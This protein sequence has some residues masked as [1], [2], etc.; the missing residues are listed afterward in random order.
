MPD[1]AVSESVV[2]ALAMAYRL[3]LDAARDNELQS[4]ADTAW[5]T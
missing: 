5:V 3:R 2:A 4:V 1:P